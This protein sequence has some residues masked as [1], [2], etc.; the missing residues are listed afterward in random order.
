MSIVRPEKKLHVSCKL[1]VNNF[2][3]LKELK[4]LD[5]NMTEEGLKSRLSPDNPCILTFSIASIFR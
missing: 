2:T 1:F 5:E 4:F 3:Q